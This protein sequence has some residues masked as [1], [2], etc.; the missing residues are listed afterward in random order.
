MDNVD[1]RQA[2]ISGNWPSLVRRQQEKDIGTDYSKLPLASVM[3]GLD[4]AI[5]ALAV[6][7]IANVPAWLPDLAIRQEQ[8]RT[9]E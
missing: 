7:Q 2:V 1:S 6:N 5:Q 4:L 3:L 8:Y 9:F